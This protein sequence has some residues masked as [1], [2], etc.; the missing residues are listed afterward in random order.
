[1]ANSPRQLN[2]NCTISAIYLPETGSLAAYYARY[3]QLKD[4]NNTLPST[5]YNTIEGDQYSTNLNSLTTG[6]GGVL[7]SVNTNIGAPACTFYY[8]SIVPGEAHPI[9]DLIKGPEKSNFTSSKIY[10]LPSNAQ[11]GQNRTKVENLPEDSNTNFYS[12]NQP[13]IPFSKFGPYNSAQVRT[14][15]NVWLSRDINLPNAKIVKGLGIVN[16]KEL[17]TPTNSNPASVTTSY[18][19]T[20][21]NITVFCQN[22]TAILRRM[23]PIAD[24]LVYN[25][26]DEGQATLYYPNSNNIETPSQKIKAKGGKNC[27]FRIVFNHDQYSSFQTTTGN[28]NSS[29][30]IYWGYPTTDT[31]KKVVSEFVLTLD[32]GKPP[33][34]RYKKNNST[35]ANN[36]N[37]ISKDWEKIVLDTI[38]V[39]T[40]SSRSF[41]LYV[42]FAGP[43]MYYGFEPNI[44]Q[45]F[46]FDS[47]KVGENKKDQSYDDFYLPS[48]PKESIIEILFRNVHATYTYEP[49]CFNNFNPDYIGADNID[50]RNRINVNFQASKADFLD[51][52]VSEENLNKTFREHRIPPFTNKKIYNQN[53]LVIPT[54]YADYRMNRGADSNLDS[55]ITEEEYVKN[56]E[57]IYQEVSNTLDDSIPDNPRYLIDGQVI[58]DTTIEGPVFFYIREFKK[59][60]QRRKITR[61]IWNQYSDVSKYLTNIRIDEEFALENKSYK[62]SKATLTFANLS[63]DIYGLQILN[64]IQ[65]N[66]L[67]FTVKA[68]YGNE[69]YTYFQ[70]YTRQVRV[71]RKPDSF[72]VTVTCD[73]LGSQLLQDIIF[74]TTSPI[75]F[76]TRSFKGIL[77]DCFYMAGLQGVYVPRSKKPANEFD[78]LYDKYFNLYVGAFNLNQQSSL[79][80]NVITVNK[81]THIDQTVKEIMGLMIFSS[82]DPKTSNTMQYYPVLFWNPEK[83]IYELK[84]RTDTPVEELFFAGDT[85]RSDGLQLMANS[86]SLREHGMITDEG[87]TETTDLRN[88]ELGYGLFSRLTMVGRLF[89]I[90]PF[91]VISENSVVNQSVGSAAFENLNNFI[92]SGNNPNEGNIQDQDVLGYIGFNRE[93]YDDENNKFYQSENILSDVFKAR[94]KS[95]RIPLHKLNFSVF[96]T[97]PLSTH[98]TFKIKSFY[99]G[100]DVSETT[101]YMF[102]NTTYIF[103]IE[104]NLI[105]ASI[106]GQ[107]SANLYE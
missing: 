50:G 97:K 40:E 81:K 75:S 102:V 25:N 77:E 51:G 82:E 67:V 32:L 44:S 1:L 39:I 85:S 49:I 30:W 106:V 100:T 84:M 14:T 47:I 20:G 83:E 45:W 48:I 78:I 36:T 90:K 24:D 55:D 70:G 91:V 52:S 73:D 88:N 12:S 59:L 16:L 53:E 96:V 42:H 104:K 34:L 31:S 35:A 43:V 19:K 98:G 58:Y 4:P 107:I 17:S 62:V 61:P 87:W 8:G 29:I 9:L 3:R 2:V 86:N 21:A 5:F 41:E 13:F 56:P 68:G 74:N 76:N 71:D 99:G 54:F 15:Y 23:F 64:A 57:I 69:S 37:S 27:G 94:T 93:K 6:S 38:P 105:R 80:S 72:T 89:D 26:G 33:I 7:P 95:I 22:K 10:Q 63:N 46:V 11:S 65:E 60:D 103:D 92:R 101:E 18:S 28:S 79:A 66:F